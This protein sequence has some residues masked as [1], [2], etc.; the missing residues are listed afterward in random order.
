[1]E[2]K[3]HPENKKQVKIL[4]LFSAAPIKIITEK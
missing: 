2:N 3:K 1:M 4:K